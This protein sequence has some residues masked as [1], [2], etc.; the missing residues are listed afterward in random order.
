MAEQSGEPIKLLTQEFQLGE[1][2]QTQTQEYKVDMEAL[3]KLIQ[4]QISEIDSSPSS[5][6]SNSL[7]A[8]PQSAAFNSISELWPNILHFLWPIPRLIY[9][10]FKFP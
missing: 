10:S 1:Q 9:V 2:K 6:L 8:I 4:F 5:R 3:R 7:T